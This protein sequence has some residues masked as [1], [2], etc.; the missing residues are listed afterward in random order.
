MSPSIS[1]FVMLR[2]TF[3]AICLALS[4]LPARAQSTAPAEVTSAPPALPA[5][6]A[7]EPNASSGWAHTATVRTALGWRDN[8]VL[9]PF[10]PIGRAFGRAELESFAIR[11]REN[12]EFLSF[13]NGSVLRYF[14]PPP[15]TSGEQEWFGHG[16]L[17]WRHWPAW[18]LA[19][20]ADAFFQDAVI[21][22][23]ETGALRIVAPTRVQGAFATAATRVAL[24]AGFALEPQFQVKRT[25]YRSFP[26]DYDE[27][28]L[29]GRLEWKR[30]ERLSLSAAWFE[31]RRGYTERQQ[32][33]AGGRARQGTHLRF[34]QRS[35]E[36][37]AST[38]W[39]TEG[40][41]TAA[42]SAARLENRDHSSGFFDYNQKEVRLELTWE[43]SRWKTKIEG[44]AKRLDYL[45]QTVGAGVTPPARLADNFEASVLVER[46]LN[47]VWSVFA[48]QRWE[49]SR[50]NEI[51]FSY[52]ANTVLAGIQRV[53]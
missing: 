25:D 38:A 48:Q 34:W 18:R 9:S 31:H 15:E 5:G 14:S 11:S 28:R 10:T 40:A 29:G 36:L 44:E 20:K 37:K 24:P 13:V 35:G 23:S 16:E 52:R 27:V 41:W 19:L 12:W 39:Q 8:V 26:G 51:G 3:L 53:F 33:T 6:A 2:I 46:E 45:V 4:L 21:D 42:V 43:R 50:S 32:Y 22:L 1:A 49:R 17:R 47:A 30:S 7:P